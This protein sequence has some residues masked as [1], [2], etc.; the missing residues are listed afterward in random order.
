MIKPLRKLLGKLFRN[1]KQ[2]FTETDSFLKNTLKW[3]LTHGKGPIPFIPLRLLGEYTMNGKVKLMYWYF[4]GT[5]PPD[6]S[7]VYT[8]GQIDSLIEKIKSKSTFYYGKTDLWLYQA[9]EKFPIKDKE[10][11]IMGS[12]T[13]L[14]ESICIFF[15]GKPTTIEYN[16]IISEDNRLK[17]ITVDDYN[18]S[19]IKF[20]AAFSIS[21][22]EHDG[23]GRYGDPLNPDG[24]FL[25][26]VK[27]KAILKS[28]GI[29][30]LAV[31]VGRDAL[32]WNAHRI[33]GRNRLPLLLKDWELIDT[34][35][36]SDDLFN[37][38]SAE[39][40]IFVLKNN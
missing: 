36:L 22:F 8:R 20:D 24:D 32:V 3:M 5:Y 33:Y 7:I 15:G 39:Q 29:L 35:G 13:P 10:V 16:K 27:M 38:L 17:I 26:M 28:N 6:K 9:L 14:Y 11:A 40:P 1:I 37:N 21:S 12:V 2:R 30:F 23:L 31:P 25:A 4:N 34:F 18:K 19:K